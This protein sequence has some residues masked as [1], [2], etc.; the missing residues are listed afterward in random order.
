MTEFIHLILLTVFILFG[1]YSSM[2]NPTGLSEN[3]YFN[4]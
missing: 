1:M 3:L 4:K 2:T